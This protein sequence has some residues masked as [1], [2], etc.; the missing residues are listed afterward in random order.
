MRAHEAGA[1]HGDLGGR[2]PS[3][4]KPPVD[5]NELSPALWPRNVSRADN[6]VLQV[7]GLDVRRLAEDF[8][9]PA[10]VFDEADFRSRCRDFRQAF[11][12]V[13]VFYAAK[14]F[15]AKAVVR[16]VHE[17]GLNLDVCT[18]G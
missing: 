13:D 16:V 3:W 1:M 18:G 11:A 14:A 5:V 10:Y 15:C 7:A 9:T 12:G 17:E 6:G 2:G 8:G 4:L